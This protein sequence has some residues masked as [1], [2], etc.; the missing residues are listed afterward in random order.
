MSL[1]PKSSD[2]ELVKACIQEDRKAQKF[3][4][5][6]YFGQMIGIA[7]RYTRNRDE[8]E[9]VLNNAFLKVFKS[10]EQYSEKGKLKSWIASIVF[11]SSI[12]FVRSKAKYRSVMDFESTK[13]NPVHNPALSNMAI[14][15]LYK[16]VQTLPSSTQA[17]FSMYAIDGYKHREIA[18]HLGISVGTSKW[19]L[20]KAREILQ[21]MVLAQRST[22]EI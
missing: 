5:Q 9:E 3:L 22:S 4:Y 15:E 8:A 21:R 12:D 13:D 20:S 10:L 19:H 17:V 16:M 1:S 11:H 2:N 7:L 14:D 6:R 18:E